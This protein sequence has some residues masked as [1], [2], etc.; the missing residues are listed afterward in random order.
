MV[1]RPRG[2]EGPPPAGHVAPLNRHVRLSALA[3]LDLQQ[4]RDWFDARGPGLGD[5]FLD[6]VNDTIT[7]IAANPE[8]IRSTVADLDRAPV[9]KHLWSV[10]YRILPD[11]SIVVACLSDRRDPSLAQRRSRRKLEPKGSHDATGPIDS[12]GVERIENFSEGRG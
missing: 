7:R 5:T 4:A 8:R 2:S 1:G 6:R 3:A 12:V 11:E 9:P 10:F